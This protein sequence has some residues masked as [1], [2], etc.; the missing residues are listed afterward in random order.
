[1]TAAGQVE[2]NGEVPVALGEESRY[3]VVVAPVVSGW[4]A[5]FDTAEARLIPVRCAAEPGATV[6]RALY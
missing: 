5:I 1:M 2:W 3:L 6:G 4:C